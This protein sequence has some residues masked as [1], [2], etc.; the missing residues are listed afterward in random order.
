MFV[1][2]VG[3]AQ[4]GQQLRKQLVICRLKNVDVS[5]ADAAEIGDRDL[6]DWAAVQTL[7]HGGTV[8]ALEPGNMPAKTDAAAI[9]RY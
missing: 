7:K 8:Y 6:L 5:G 4:E 1:E 2:P 9:F 3:L